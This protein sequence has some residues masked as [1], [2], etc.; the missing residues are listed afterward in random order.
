LAQ[1][2]ALLSQNKGINVTDKL[3]PFDE[4]MFSEAGKKSGWVHNQ[5][6]ALISNPEQ[7][8]EVRHVMHVSEKGSPLYDQVILAQA[9]GGV[10]IP[11]DTHNRI[12]LQQ[13]W[14]KQTKDAN[15]WSKNF[16]EGK[17]DWE[18][19]GRVSYEVPGGFAKAGETSTETAKRE[20]EEET[21]SAVVSIK[22]LGYFSNNRAFSPHLDT[23]TWGRVDLSKKPAEQADPNEKLIGKL[24]FFTWKQVCELI[25]DGKLYDGFTLSALLILIAKCPE[26][27]SDQIQACTKAGT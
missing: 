23:V 10:F 7:S 25:S 2:N 22:P 21:N 5:N 19:I 4:K 8:V 17:I 15:A 14:R 26:I 27:L 6:G 13:A 16:K 3:K 20:A 1:A 9:G 12:G 18:E 24:E 11:I